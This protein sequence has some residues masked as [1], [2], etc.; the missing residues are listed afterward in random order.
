MMSF[1]NFT[2][3]RATSSRIFLRVKI[4]YSIIGLFLKIYYFYVLK[5][6]F[7]VVVLIAVLKQE[8]FYEYN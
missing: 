7:I 4:L 3:P 6:K 8:Y 1:F 2:S 5:I